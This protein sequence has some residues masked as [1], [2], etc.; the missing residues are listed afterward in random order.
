MID[1]IRLNVCIIKE[2]K[3]ASRHYLETHLDFGK[4]DHRG[5]LAKT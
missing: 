4:L 3:D 2:T 5:S 1:S